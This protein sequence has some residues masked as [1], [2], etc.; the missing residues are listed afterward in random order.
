LVIDGS[1]P[2]LRRRERRAAPGKQML[3]TALAAND[4]R[5]TASSRDATGAAAFG[6]ED[7]AHNQSFGFMKYRGSFA[8]LAGRAT[9][10]LAS[11]A[12]S[13]AE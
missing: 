7:A 9:V 5:L 13:T 2:V 12:I 10:S 4:V 1:G 8:T 11:I 6:N 3:N